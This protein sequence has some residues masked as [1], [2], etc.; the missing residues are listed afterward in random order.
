MKTVF[1]IECCEGKHKG[2]EQVPFCSLQVQQPGSQGACSFEEEVQSRSYLVF[3]VSV[4]TVSQMNSLRKKRKQVDRT[5]MT[6]S[7]ELEVKQQP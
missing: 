2:A 7:G 1:K 4:D 6:R 3:S 5:D